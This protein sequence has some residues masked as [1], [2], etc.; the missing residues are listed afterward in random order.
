M[1]WTQSEASTRDFQ[2]WMS[3]NMK[4]EAEV[5]Q[6][7]RQEIRKVHFLSLICFR[8][9]NCAELSK[10]LQENHRKDDMMENEDD[11]R[12]EIIFTK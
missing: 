9:L 5:I 11:E 6:K 2:Y 7:G 3:K 12:N 1:Q 8:L 4:P 10:H